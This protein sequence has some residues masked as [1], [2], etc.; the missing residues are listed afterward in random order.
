MA[1]LIAQYLLMELTIPQQQPKSG[2]SHRESLR[3][4]RADARRAAR[5]FYVVSFPKSGRTWLRV[6]LESLKLAANYTHDGSGHSRTGHIDETKPASE[7]FAGKS[8][9]FLY[10]DPRDTVV[11]GY[12]QASN[13]LKTYAGSIS[14]FI[15]DPRHGIEKVV[16]FNME[17]LARGDSCCRFYPVTYEELLADTVGTLTRIVTFIGAERSLEAIKAVVD[18]TSFEKMQEKE[19]SGEFGEQYG[20]VLL[21][22][23]I[24]DPQSFKVREGIVGG[25]RKH[26]GEDDV[27]FCNEV[28][29]RLGYP[30][31]YH[32][33]QHA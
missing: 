16:H 19:M 30:L 8:V 4:A 14:D 31:D 28:L 21:P 24:N 25:F 1:R 2:R 23:D 7:A 26:L 9:V 22:T 11:S 20:K 17:W 13:R 15:R 33:L 5:S 32:S 29:A 3:A 27:A 6:M 18:E 10:R 12:F